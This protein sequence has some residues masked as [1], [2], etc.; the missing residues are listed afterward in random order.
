[1][2]A[3]DNLYQVEDGVDDVVAADHN[4]NVLAIQFINDTFGEYYNFG[5]GRDG[6]L[7]VGAISA[8]TATAPV[9]TSGGAGLLT[10]TFYY[11]YTAYNLSGE[12][13]PSSASSTIS[14]AAGQAMVQLAGTANSTNITGFRLYRSIDDATYYR[15]GEF[16][17]EDP[18]ENVTVYDN[19]NISSGTAPDGSNTTGATATISG[20][21]KCKTFT[22]QSGQ[23]INIEDDSTGHGYLAI[24][25]NTSINV[26]GTINGNG[27]R[28]A[29]AMPSL[30][31]EQDASGIFY[32]RTD[33]L[34][35]NRGGKRIAGPNSNKAK[36]LLARKTG[37]FLSSGAGSIVTAGGGDTNPG[38]TLILGSP[39]VD[40]S[41]STINLNA[42]N[43][44]SDAGGSGGGIMINFA[45]VLRLN[46]ATI[47][48]NGGNGTGSGGASTANGG[49][50]GIVYNV[51]NFTEGS[52]TISV[53]AGANATNASSSAYGGGCGGEGGSSQQVGLILTALPK[54]FKLDQF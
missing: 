12:T 38:G 42:A 30:V 8:T 15:V 31:F 32:A 51:S 41:S 13:A 44:A 7:K 18:T 24:I 14:L 37:W 5:S 16:P 1:M 48:A 2:T 9:A 46:A 25:A 11:K 50:G 29:S 49:G 21:Y 22:L 43:D 35:G 47:N 34:T 19:I 20:G 3:I 27:V 28:T 17:V 40:I 33:G 45:N 53:N 26:Q 36:T 39:I 52:A 10:G 23:T 54:D 4:T 6:H